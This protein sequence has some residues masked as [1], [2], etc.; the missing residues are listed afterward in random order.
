MSSNDLINELYAI[1]AQKQRQLYVAALAITRE[2]S[3]AEDSVHDALVAMASL[4]E[5]PENLEAYLFRTVRNKALHVIKQRNRVDSNT[6]QDEFLDVEE[7]SASQK[8]FVSQIAERM[9]KLDENSRQVL[10]MKLFAD[11][12]FK[13]IASIMQSPPNTI[14]SWYRRGIE[15]LKEEVYE[16]HI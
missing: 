6:D 1:F 3:S 14:A 4:S 10:I 11:L 9:N 15:K 8:I 2:R 5:K 7:C 12:T 16:Q 13:E